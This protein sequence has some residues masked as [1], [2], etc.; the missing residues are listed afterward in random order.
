MTPEERKRERARKRRKAKTA[1]ARAAATDEP[2][3]YRSPPKHSR[4]KPGKSGNPSGRPKGKASFNDIVER[5]V[6]TLVEVN[7]GGRRRKLPAIEAI[8]L[9]ALQ[10]AM[11]G[12]LQSAKLVMEL[13]KSRGLAGPAAGSEEALAQQFA[14]A[15]ES[16]ARKLEAALAEDELDGFGDGEAQRTH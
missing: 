9:R 8:L 15:R 14:G 11:Q 1:K 13:H 16:L 12:D 10:K 7:I 3:G 4:F 6:M 5:S 2:V